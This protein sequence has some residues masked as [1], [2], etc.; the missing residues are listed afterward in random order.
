MKVRTQNSRC[1]ALGERYRC[2]RCICCKFI[3]CR[4]CSRTTN[5]GCRK[6]FRNDFRRGFMKQKLINREIKCIND[7]IV[8]AH[9][10]MQL[11]KIEQAENLLEDAL[12]SIRAVKELQKDE[13]VVLVGTSGFRGLRDRK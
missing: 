9:A 2:T 5:C 11:S 7:C 13:T 6:Y 10:S 12:K 4:Y 8:L 1:I 3:R